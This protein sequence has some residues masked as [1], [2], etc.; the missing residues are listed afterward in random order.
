MKKQIKNYE[1]PEV[2]IVEINV[3]KGFASTEGNSNT[4]NAGTSDPN[5]G[6]GNWD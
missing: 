4:G 1:T 3:E 6:E 5:E 2:E